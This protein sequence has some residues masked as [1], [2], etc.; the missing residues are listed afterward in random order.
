MRPPWKVYENRVPPR[1]TQHWPTIKNGYLAFRQPERTE[2]SLWPRSNDY[3]RDATVSVEVTAVVQQSGRDATVQVAANS[4]GST[5]LMEFGL[6]H[7]M[8]HSFLR[9]NS[10][11]HHPCLPS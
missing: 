9:A 11:R 2:W 1:P 7:Q 3:T 6:A 10:G 8:L 5:Q 4:A